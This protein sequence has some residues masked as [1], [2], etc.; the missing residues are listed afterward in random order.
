[1]LSYFSTAVVSVLVVLGL[2][3]LLSVVAWL[4]SWLYDAILAKRDW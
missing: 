4:L 1:M 3:I 2:A